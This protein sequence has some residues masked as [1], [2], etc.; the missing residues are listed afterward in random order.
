MRLRALN[1]VRYRPRIRGWSAPPRNCRPYGRFGWCKKIVH[2]ID[3]ADECRMPERCVDR[4]GLS[5]ADQGRGAGTAELRDLRAT[6]LDRARAQCG[7]AASQRVQ[8]VNWQLP[9]RFGREVGEGST[10]GILG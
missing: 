6:C 3:V 7:N 2:E 8:D 10:G 4:V 1:R 5:P 9:A